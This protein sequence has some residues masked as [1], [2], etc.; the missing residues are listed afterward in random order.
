MEV[1]FY[2]VK[3]RRKV[4][5]PESKIRK[6]KYERAAKDGHTVTRYALRGEN[7]G[8]KLTKF[9]SEADWRG[10]DVPEE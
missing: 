7:E 2:D 10:M 9:V 4:S 5:V 8:T 3:L 6:T 1:E